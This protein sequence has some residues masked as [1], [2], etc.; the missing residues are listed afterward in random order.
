M[1]APIPGGAQT[2]E[3][4]GDLQGGSFYCSAK[5]LKYIFRRQF[6]L[7]LWLDFIFMIACL[8]PKLLIFK[9]SA[10][11]PRLTLGIQLLTKL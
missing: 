11:Q 7:T 3:L 5:E 9:S 6:L 8:E 4:G 10:Q 2:E 1:I